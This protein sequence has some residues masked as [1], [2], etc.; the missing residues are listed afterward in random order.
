LHPPGGRS[1]E[2]QLAWLAAKAGQA[3]E[4]SYRYLP[5][6][7]FVPIKPWRQNDLYLVTSAWAQPIAV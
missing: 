4:V 3:R 1:D 6:L 5:T 2:E 7:R